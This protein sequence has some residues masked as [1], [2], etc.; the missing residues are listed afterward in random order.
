MDAELRRLI[1]DYQARVVWAVEQIERTF[2]VERPPSA[3]EWIG[4]QIPHGVAPDGNRYYKHGFG[5]VVAYE[6]GAVDFDFGEHG[7]IGGFDASRLFNFARRVEGGYGFDSERQIE[8][9]I[10]DA[11]ARGLVRFSGY[12]L[13][14]LVDDLPPHGSNPAA[15]LS[16]DR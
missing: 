13:Y 9:A 12:I 1:R 15:A 14:Y 5:I 8:T 7:E 3:T 16:S 11:E 10:K 4:Y 6:G 2:G